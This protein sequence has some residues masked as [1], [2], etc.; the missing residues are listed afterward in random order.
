MNRIVLLSGVVISFLLPLC[1]ITVNITINS[2]RTPHK[3]N[4][5]WTHATGVDWWVIVLFGI[6]LFGAIAALIRLF[7]AF[8]RVSKM[9]KDGENHPQPDGNTI[10]IIDSHEGERHLSPSSWM[11]YIFLR[12]EDYLA[13][14]ATGFN[15]SPVYCHEAAHSALHHSMDL[16]L[17]DL[18]LILQWFNPAIWLLRRQLAAIHEYEADKAVLDKGFN[19]REYQFLLVQKS[20]SEAGYSVVNNFNQSALKGRIE[21]MLRRPSRSR[22]A[23]RLLVLIPLVCIGLALN[24][25][26]E[27]QIGQGRPFIIVGD[28]ENI[29]VRVD[30][31]EFDKDRLDEI[32]PSRIK[33]MNIDKDGKGGGTINIFMKN[34]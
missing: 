8:H 31:K 28:N 29:I 17:M 10:V 25:R 12:R 16:L 14:E 7:I 2:A 20:M 23:L 3:P 19:P 11:G 27:F 6:F 18:C 13:A 9:I 26:W 34:E 4:Y 24:A 32:D 1:I 15:S 5:L 33:S 22:R 21:M 30:G